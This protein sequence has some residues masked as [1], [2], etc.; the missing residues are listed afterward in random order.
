LNLTDV[1]PLWA[2]G[3]IA[4]GDGHYPTFEAY[5]TK[6]GRYTPGTMIIEDS[7]M[8]RC[9]HMVAGAMSSNSFYV[10]R[11]CIMTDMILAGYGAYQD[12][13]GG[14][15][16]CEVYNCT[17]INVPCDYR[18]ELNKA[19]WGS[20][21]GIGLY[22]RGGFGLYYNNTLGPFDS[23]FPGIELTNDQTNPDY[24]LHN[25]W[26]WNNTF[27]NTTSQ[28]QLGINW[29]NPTIP[30]VQNV[31]YFLRAPLSSEL[32]YTALPYPFLLDQYGNPGF[33]IS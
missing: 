27:T 1:Q 13:H 18:S 21:T 14:G 26:V 5:T 24:K 31:D 2:Y 8:A 15:L 22:S 20:Y 33:P 10:L 32:N 25:V 3:I 28:W 29:N 12:V 4:G 23:V 6:L 11:H 17:I 16:G 9:R 30:V 7:T 19:Y